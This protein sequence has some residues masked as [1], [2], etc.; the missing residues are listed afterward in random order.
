[1][2]AVSRWY[3]PFKTWKRTDFKMRLLVR[4]KR[5][6]SI[7]AWCT[8]FCSCACC[9]SVLT[10]YQRK[11]LAA[12]QCKFEFRSGRLQTSEFWIVGVHSKV[13]SVA[14]TLYW[15]QDERLYCGRQISSL[16]LKATWLRFEVRN[17]KYGPLLISSKKTTIAEQLTRWK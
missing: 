12:P 16:E 11:L 13:Q 8:H 3:I 9:H 10:L 15:R 2:P 14:W 4:K 7:F 1:M 5:C 6:L 17:F